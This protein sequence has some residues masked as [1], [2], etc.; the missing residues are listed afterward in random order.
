ML[1]AAILDSAAIHL[2]NGTLR[3][4]YDELGNLYKVPAFCITFPENMMTD[5]DKRGETF[6]SSCFYTD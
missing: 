4:A 3:L 1:T 5:D 2:P 6:S